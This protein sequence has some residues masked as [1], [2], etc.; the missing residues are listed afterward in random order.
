MLY[1]SNPRGSLLGYAGVAVLLAAVF[2]AALVSAERG[3]WPGTIFTGLR[4][5]TRL[6]PVRVFPRTTRALAGHEAQN[7]LDA[8]RPW[9]AW[10]LVRDEV[11]DREALPDFVLLG[12]RA[13]AGWGGWQ[14]VRT[15]LEKRDWL[16]DVENGD[17]LFL[18]GRADEELG[19]HA[20]AADAYRRY[21]ALSTAKE[22]GVAYARLGR[23]LTAAKDPLGAA[24]A[25]AEAAREM[26][27][28][29]DWLGALQLEQEVV[30]GG[31]APA[32]PGAQFATAGAP[33]R[34]RRVAAEARGWMAV[35]DVPRALAR[36]QAE[37]GVLHGQGALPQV[38][39]LQLVRADLLTK[40]GRPR[41]ARELLRLAAAEPGV[42][43]DTRLGAARRLG[44]IEGLTVQ[45]ELA[46]AAVYEA[47]RKPG[48]AA[49][50]LRAAMRLGAGDDGAMQLRLAH[51]LYD[52]G[53]DEP[54]RL[55]FQRAAERL[56]DDDQVAEAKLF[57]ARSLFRG[58]GK[59]RFDA[60]A[61]LK[62]V[63]ERYP[64][65]AAA[66]SALFMLGDMASNMENARSY[67]RRAAS[68]HA[69]VDAREALYRVGDRSIRMKDPATAIHSWEEYVSRFP[70]GE[71]TARVA[72]ET[73][74]LH[75]KAGRASRARAMFTASML[76][77]PT[78]YYAM[79]SSEKL[80]V[81]AIDHVLAEPRPWLGL[82]TDPAAAAVVLQRL[83]ELE[84]IGERGAWEA[85]LQDGIR[86]LGKRPAA[87]IALSEGVRER[88]YPVQAINLGWKLWEMRERKWDARLLRVI[89]PLLYRDQILAE[90][91]RRDIDP[92]LLAGLVRQE[93][94]F[95]HDARS[96]VDAT[97]L[98]QIM[99]RTGEELA[100]TAG[101]RNFDR[102][103]L[104]VPEI[105]LRMG[106][107]YLQDLLDRYH[108]T[109][110][111]ALAAYN[112][113]P[114]RVDK[115]RRELPSRDRDAF[116]EGIPF[117]ETRG[118]VKM[119]LRNAALYRRLY[120]K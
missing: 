5:L 3:P 38:G 49:R 80:E 106:A 45:E 54:A 77:E 56:S 67:Y 12:S 98:C 22:R 94:S 72:Y 41:E 112:A 19:D 118:Y 59:R 13:A 68:V 62:K 110:D 69:S 108:D 104:E 23:V 20:A 58:G 30:A 73:G 47:A 75:E 21:V 57:A 66:G 74:K 53:D 27:E 102:E 34:A 17:G 24:R 16:Q 89:F 18:L 85:E 109:P 60:I 117:A 107:E 9:E 65:S 50:E 48:I 70:A 92:M 55:A 105:N 90:A 43:L 33:A 40:A 44:E 6:E 120:S 1:K 39:E 88:G 15:L 37:E 7:A 91:D 28:V 95:R 81:S 76:A 26:P 78:S 96:R 42:D 115:W 97:G 14:N 8:G 29:E 31:R 64:E 63:A 113:G 100:P 83:D 36:L 25:Y 61:E 46:V 79:R 93:S 82:A 114:G 52:E 11:F 4:D 101:V 119:V 103:L 32:P 116:R 87:L 84:S 99:P 71:A 35:G 2:G 51:L 86:A 10:R 111:L